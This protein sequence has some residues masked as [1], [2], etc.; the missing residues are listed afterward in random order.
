MDQFAL[1]VVVVIGGLLTVGPIV[2][3][4]WLMSRA[5]TARKEIEDLN[6][7]VDLLQIQVAQLAK[8]PNQSAQP[9]EEKTAPINLATLPPKRSE[10]IP[11]MVETPAAPAPETPP[12]VQPPP[13]IPPLVSSPVSEPVIDPATAFE[14]FQSTETAEPEPEP[15]ATP[16]LP[17]KS[18]FEMRLGTFW[19]VRIGVVMLLT[20]FAFFANYAY[21]HVVPKLGPGGKIS[22]LYLASGLLLGAGAWWQRRNVKESL[23]NYAQVLFAGGL[24]AVYFTTYAAHHI[25]PLRVIGSALVDGTLLLAWAG[26]IAW[27][28]D[29]RKSEVMALF[30][31]G[32]AF[33]TS[34]ITRVGEFTLWSNLILTITAVVFLVRNRWAT[35]SF[36]SLATS[37]AGY[38]FWRFLHADG[39]RW[40]TPDENLW[41]G[42]GFLAGYWVVF[43]TATFLSKCEKLSGLN[44][45]AFLTLNNGA[46]FSLFLLTMLQVHSGGFWKLSLGFG[47]VLLALAAL[48]Q[49]FL[50]NERPSKNAYLTQGLL[51]VTLGFITKFSGLQLSLVL[52]AECVVLYV[53][54]AQRQSTV[55]KFFAHAAAWLAT[56]W[57]IASLNKFDEQG[58]WTGAG[59][60]ALLVFNAFWA[61]R[62][63]AAKSESPLRSEPT[64]FTLLA[65][66]CWLATT[67]FNTSDANLPL[68]LAAE[69]V[70]LT[71]SF[72]LLRVR[73]ITLLGQFFLIIAQLAWLVHFM[74]HTPPWWNPLAIIAVTI[75]LSHWWQHQKILAISRNIFVCYSTIFALAAVGVALVWLHPLVSPPG[76]LALTSLLAVA[77]T[78]Y[79]VATRAWPL[80]ICGQIFLALSAWEFL[81]QLIHEKPEWY[82]PLAP[83][84]V[85][86]GLSF[87]TVAWFARKPQ[88]QS[89][90][91][92]P[93]LQLALVYRW[94]ALLMSLLWIWQ[95]VPER[96]RVW[97]FMLAAVGVFTLGVWRRSREALVAVAVYGTS[98]LTVLWLRENF[99]METT[100]PNFLSLLAIFAMQQ[101]LRRNS[102]KLPL[103]EVNH[104]VMVFIAGLSLWRFLS[105][106]V[107]TSG[108]FLTM[109]WAG[110]AVLVFTAGMILRERF[111]RWFG[112]GVLAASVGR[113]VLVDVWKQETIYR[114]L[115]FMALGVALL[116][117]GFI[118]NKFQ[119][120]IRKWL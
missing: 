92:S 69:A 22:L 28:A 53:F 107:P 12:I 78:I 35:L 3:I 67:Y 105:C 62:M 18:S 51:L 40:A 83:L 48:A 80:A 14:N 43:T 86:A 95:Y 117:V 29:R 58:L 49:K 89:N 45:A 60:G 39:W 26:V 120:T 55:L 59:L 114:V 41:L 27:I 17:E 96:Q 116:V 102:A 79:G 16:P 20:G 103:A 72:Y 56:G 23:K 68:A 30:A 9:P 74:N 76:W 44:R 115:T 57:C 47:S 7:R 6:R 19:L 2:V 88:T 1:F 31:V 70:A 81:A 33:F 63:D 52:G 36:A 112:L 54:G 10:D 25:P 24:A 85:L 50:P 5:S 42:A 108:L 13:I 82:F 106:W 21:H 66:A 38:A 99:E 101:I 109:S 75:G 111:L 37:Y 65:F 113:V 104:G 98:S 90:V 71:F 64:A 97:A 32:L 100:L 34:V 77:V 87:A 84:A 94:L 119:D 110:F 93:L 61:H 8:K 118:Y 91:R 11:P 73:E 46:F 4:I 15:T